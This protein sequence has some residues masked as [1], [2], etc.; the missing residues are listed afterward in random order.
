TF[1]RRFFNGGNPVGRAF[2]Q[3]GD[4]GNLD[5]VYQVIGLVQDAKYGDLREEFMPIVFTAD[6]QD[7]TQRPGTRIVILASEPAAAIPPAAPRAAAEA[8]PQFVAGSRPLKATIGEG[9]LRERLMA[10]LSGFFGGLAAILAM[11]G[12]YSVLSFMVA[13]RRNEIGVR[14]ALGA[15]RRDILGM[16]IREAATLV[17]IGLAV[18]A[19][20][21]LAAAT[22]A[23]TLLYGLQPSDPTTPGLAAA[24]LTIVALSSSLLPAHRAAS[25]DPNQALHEE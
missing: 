11:I 14:M 5:T 21:A 25:I 15:G 24:A 22:T 4:G 13:R 23:Q 12:I 2:A 18:G 9:L 6:A 7:E 8:G 3:K 16:V 17:G 10:T 19:L 1:A 20:L